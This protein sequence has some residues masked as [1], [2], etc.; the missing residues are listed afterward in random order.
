MLAPFLVMETI[1]NSKG[2]WII[3]YS[4]RVSSS[5]D[6]GPSV[7]AACLVAAFSCA[8]PAFVVAAPVP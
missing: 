2:G 7:L 1:R 8:F 3:D 4:M 6:G 5:V